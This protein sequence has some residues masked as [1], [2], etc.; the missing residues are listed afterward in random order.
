VPAT[1]ALTLTP[2]APVVTASNHQIVTVPKLSLLLSTFAPTVVASSL[3]TV[4]GPP[5][6]AYAVTLNVG[7]SPL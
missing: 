4:A 1:V 6:P 3:T 5:P 7:G 2:L